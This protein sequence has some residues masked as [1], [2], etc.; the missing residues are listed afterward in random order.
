[1]SEGRKLAYLVLGGLLVMAGTGMAKFAPA[2]L[3][4]SVVGIALILAGGFVP[5]T[6]AAPAVR[7][8]G[9]PAT[10]SAR[11]DEPLSRWLWLVKWA[12]AI[13]HAVILVFLWVAFGVLTVAAFVAILFTGRYPE[14][15]FATNVGI[16]RWSWRVGF[17]AYSALGTDRY[18]PFTLGEAAYPAQLSVVYP[19]ELSRGLALVKWWL[20]AIPHYLIIAIFSGTSPSADSRGVQTRGGLLPLLVFFAGVA[21]LFT[22]RYPRGIFDLIIG[23]HRWIYR[24]VTYVALMHDAYPPFRVDLGGE[25]PLSA[26]ASIVRATV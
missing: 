4:L 10:L 1:M 12:L 6:S 7:G 15:L 3:L 8:E 26:P 21:L 16:M 9:Y 22:G 18:P 14:P 13:P 5:L 17:Y 25:E 2:G 23:L 19:G 11:L 24:V 20:L